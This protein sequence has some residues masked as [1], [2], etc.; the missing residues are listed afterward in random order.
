MLTAQVITS[1]DVDD[2]E[3]SGP[4]SAVGTISVTLTPGLLKQYGQR[5][6]LQGT[7]LALESTKK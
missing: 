2:S 1:T 4:S 5:C 3:E 6:I 7:S